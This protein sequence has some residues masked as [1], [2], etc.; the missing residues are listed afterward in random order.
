LKRVNLE[1]RARDLRYEFLNRTADAVKAHFIAL[2]HHRDDQAETVL[3]RLLRGAGIAGLAAMAEVGPGRL[4]RPL[5][6]L[7][8]T[9]IFAYLAAIGAAHVV[10]SSNYDGGALRNRVRAELLPLLARDYSP[11]IGRRLAELASEMREVD[12]FLVAEAR[13]CLSARLVA[14]SVAEQS[15][16]CTMTLVGFRSI[17]PALARAILRQF[18]RQVVGD[19][20]RIERAH[21]EAMHRLAVGDHPSARV[22]LPGGWRLR[23]EYDRV[24]L[25]RC[26]VPAERTSPRVPNRTEIRLMWGLARA[27]VGGFVLT[28]ESLASSEPAFPKPPW[29]TTDGFEAYFDADE[30]VAL[31]VRCIRKGD[32]IRPLG[33][34]GS[35]K[36]HDV[37]IDNKVPVAKRQYW[38]VVV[39]GE[40]VVWIPGL[41]RSG[42]ALVTAASKKVLHLRA[43][44]IEPG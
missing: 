19:L 20:R 43:N 5:L 36:L 7:Q 24:V 27:M 40:E 32:R 9:S 2:G 28:V 16:S 13:R 42:V 8:R 34:V 11:R 22:S 26:P 37:F 12:S 31:G 44:R 41:V 10:D 14:P 3:L 17:S 25:E 33:L 29:H 23:R 39:L 35:R 15:Q 21:I 1:E 4:I 30:A 18:T 38:P 6:S